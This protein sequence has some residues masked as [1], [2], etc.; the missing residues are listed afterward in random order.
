MRI[1]IPV[2]DGRLFGHFGH[3][4]SF[5]LIDADA[6]TGAITAREDLAA[7]PHEP[8]LLPKWLGERGV[9]LVM[10]GGIGPAARNLLAKRG[11]AVLTGVAGDTPEAL[12]AAHFAG[13]LAT[14]VNGCDHDGEAG[15]GHHHHH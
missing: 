5:A 9:N 8:G 7:P 1:A 2:E 6:E 12:V 4:P 11:I 13:T 14:G 3:A 10:T 15:H